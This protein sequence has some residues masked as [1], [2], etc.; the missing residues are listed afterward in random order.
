M[1]I[2]GSND[3]FGANSIERFADVSKLNSTHEDAKGWLDG[4]PSPVNFW[5]KDKAVK[6]DAYQQVSDNKADTYG[7]DAVTAFYHSGHGLNSGGRVGVPMGAIYNGQTWVYSDQMS[8]GDAELRYLFWS[9]CSA[10]ATP[11][12]SWWLPNKG[13]LRMM[14]GYSTTTWDMMGYGKYFWK[15]VNQGKSFARA[16]QDA[17]YLL[18]KVQKPVVLASAATQAEARAMLANERTFSKVPSVKGWYEWQTGSTAQGIVQAG[19]QK[20]VTDIR[21]V[22]RHDKEKFKGAAKAVSI[23]DEGSLSL[24][25]GTKG[26]NRKEFPLAQAKAAA[27]R[28]ISDYRLDEGIELVEGDTSTTTTQGGTLLGSGRMDEPTV[29]ETRVQFR[30]AHSG[31][32][33]IGEG[34][35]V[36]NVDV[37]NDGS[38]VAIHDSTRKIIDEKPSKNKA[39]VERSH[40][41]HVRED[42]TGYD[43]S[44]G[45]MTRQEDIEIDF[46]HGLKKNY[47]IRTEL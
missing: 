6:S 26:E 39:H 29:I 34:H 38:I 18:G 43:F 46:G 24:F 19:G 2:S 41:K 33:S 36:I 28:A 9:I 11:L 21:I 15:Y 7:M 5:L 45:K 16:F 37:D 27:R 14:F 8:F 40:H 20:A 32:P 42:R 30:Q 22:P 47:R 10:L 12:Q 1:I 25:F 23:D 35:G 4:C 17:S 31:I 44:T 3:N 13:G